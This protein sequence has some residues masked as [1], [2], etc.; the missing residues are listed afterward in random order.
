MELTTYVETLRHELSVAAEA[1]GEDARALAE[2]LTAAIDSATRLVLLEALSAAAEEIT[3][4]LAPG[5]VDVRLRGRNPRFVVTPPPTEE[6]FDDTTEVPGSGPTAPPEILTDANEGGTA[7]IN[8][9]LPESLKTRAEEAAGREGLSVNAWL[10]RAVA[11]VLES[12]DRHDQ[13]HRPAPRGG[14]R[15]TGWV[16]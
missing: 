5:S 4:E 13:S 16:R 15:Y 6:S 2:R 1:A 14:Q 10:V 8:L 11:T 7:R 3:S 9:R 12:A